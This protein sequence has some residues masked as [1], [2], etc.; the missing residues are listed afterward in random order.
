MPHEVH[1]YVLHAIVSP[2]SM[3]ALSSK[4]KLPKLSNFVQLNKILSVCEH[5]FCS[6]PLPCSTVELLPLAKN[7]EH[8]SS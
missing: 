8:S 1:Y 5:T 7:V 4:A 6:S 3:L 2:W